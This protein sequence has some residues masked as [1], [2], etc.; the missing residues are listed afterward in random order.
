MS[1]TGKVLVTAISV[2]S[3]LRRPAALQAAAIRARTSPRL[4]LSSARRSARAAGTFVTGT[5]WR[6]PDQPGEP[7][8]AA[9]APVGEQ[10][11]RLGGA[12]AVTAYMPDARAG[13]LRLDAGP[14]VDSRR[15]RP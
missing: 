2:T 7:P 9:I 4:A 11:G 15:A 8:C 6:E 10:L 12:P 14:D 3:S 5:S 1:E 13:Q